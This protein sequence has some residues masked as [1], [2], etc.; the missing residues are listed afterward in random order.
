MTLNDNY[1]KQTPGKAMTDNLWLDPYRGR[2]GIDVV[3]DWIVKNGNGLFNAFDAYPG[4]WV[5][6]DGSLVYGSVLLGCRDALLTLSPVPTTIWVS[7]H[8]ILHTP[9]RKP[10]RAHPRGASRFAGDRDAALPDLS[11]DAPQ[12]AYSA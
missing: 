1:F 6:Q 3:Y 8:G 4:I 12:A 2:S 11:R 5:K 7:S 9:T 10:T